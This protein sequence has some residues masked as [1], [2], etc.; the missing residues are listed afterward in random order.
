MAIIVFCIYIWNYL[1]GQVFVPLPFYSISIPSFHQE[2]SVLLSLETLL[3]K[4]NVGCV[5][6]TWMSIPLRGSLLKNLLRMGFETSST[7][8]A[9]SILQKQFGHL[10]AGQKILVTYQQKTQ[11]SL[12]HLYSLSLSLKAG[13]TITIIERRPGH[14]FF[15]KTTVPL[16]TRFIRL[17]G[18]I[19]SN[20][21]QDLCRLGNTQ[22]RANYV[23]RTLLSAGINW[24][25]HLSPGDQY[26]FLCRDVQTADGKSNPDGIWMIH[27]KFKKGKP[28]TAYRY[29][30]SGHQTSSFY[31]ADGI[32]HC[33]NFLKRPIGTAR[34]SSQF[35]SRQHPLFGC[36]K[37]HTGVD[38]AAASGSPVMAAADGVVE[39]IGWYSGYGKYVRLRHGQGYLT[40][41]GHLK[42]YAQNLR[43]GQSVK[44]GQ[45]IAFVGST[46]NAT[47]PHLHFEVL[48]GKK[49]LNPLTLAK[50][51]PMRLTGL[52]KLKFQRYIEKL[53]QIHQQAEIEAPI[54]P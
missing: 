36:K 37:K 4:K 10:P 15:S 13:T 18:V 34:L 3:Q 17:Q 38:W 49:F 8:M 27:I 51:V 12:R 2:E 23:I 39:K 22:R 45:V 53:R 7:R 42:N 46:G 31:N 29:Q 43:L 14:Y 1:A 28:F 33:Q 52:Q 16:V 11:N 24:R 54:K 30:P 19:Q 21:V 40:A 26:S 9:L 5:S 20:L 48:K 25:L 47:G 44:Q 6:Q 41:Y 50:E 32:S 35:G